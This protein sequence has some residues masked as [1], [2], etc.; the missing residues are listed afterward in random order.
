MHLTLCT[1]ALMTQMPNPGEVPTFDKADRLAKA[2]QHANVSVQAMADYL[3]VSRNT[4]GN[5]LARRTPVPRASVIA[6]ALK[7]GVPFKWLEEGTDTEA[8]GPEG[9]QRARGDSNSQP[10]D[11]ESANLIDFDAYRLVAA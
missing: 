5:Y 3:G 8:G 9:G 11:L 6:W 7:T 2:L 1:M 10:S 4:V